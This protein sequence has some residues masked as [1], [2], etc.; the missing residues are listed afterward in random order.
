MLQP[1]PTATFAHGAT[2]SPYGEA[3]RSESFRPPLMSI[4]SQAEAA[5]CSTHPKPALPVSCIQAVP[6]VVH[7]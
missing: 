2:I 7:T 3:E 1:S 5:Y 6:Q 4:A